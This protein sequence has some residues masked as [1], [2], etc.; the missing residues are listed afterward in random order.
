VS[1]GLILSGWVI[2]LAVSRVRRDRGRLVT[3]V[4]LTGLL[5]Q[6]LIEGNHLVNQR[7]EGGGSTDRQDGSFNL[8]FQALK[9]QSALGAIVVFE[10][11]DK[12]LEFLRV[13]RRGASLT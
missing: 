13:S 11:S 1:G 6:S 5:E 8:R 12:G 9:K 7:V 2:V 3:F 10:R 4:V